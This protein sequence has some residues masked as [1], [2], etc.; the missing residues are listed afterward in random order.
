MPILNK[1]FKKII[2]KKHFATH[3]FSLTLSQLSYFSEAC[4]S[5]FEV[6]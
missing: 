3:F 6:P 4:N 5:F 2:K 1:L